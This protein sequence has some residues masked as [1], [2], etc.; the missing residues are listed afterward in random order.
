MRFKLELSVHKTNN[1]LPINYQYE[2]SSWIYKV[3]QQGNFDFAKWLHNEG[4]QWQN[5]KFKLLTFSQIFIQP[6]WKR[7]GDRIHILS[8][9]ASLQISFYLQE[10]VQNFLIGIFQEQQFSIGD[11]KTRAEFQIT[12][13]EPLPI[14]R[15]ENEAE[16]SCLSPIVLSKYIDNKKH[17]EYL[18]PE[19]EEYSEYFFNNLIHKYL[20][21]HTASSDSFT[22]FKRETE[23]KSPLKLEPLSTSK[24]RLVKIKAG[25]KDETK[26][27]G[28]IQKFK[29]VAPSELIEFGYHAGFGE[30]NAIG[31]GY[32]EVLN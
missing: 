11:S 30:K 9:K 4:C 31:F 32:T 13:V 19:H 17:P 8:G 29:I 26:I 25:K 10:A 5:K 2:V 16:L 28:Y 3:L 12:K 21:A 7:E 27:K 18:S 23:R 14:P 15:F 6:Q 1:I 20:I 24:S 22:D